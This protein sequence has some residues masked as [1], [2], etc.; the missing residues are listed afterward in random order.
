[1]LIISN[2]LYEH[3]WSVFANKA[4][5]RCLEFINYNKQRNYSNRYI[6]IGGFA[7]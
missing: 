3:N 1:M 6:F 2:W 7:G 4:I 5:Q